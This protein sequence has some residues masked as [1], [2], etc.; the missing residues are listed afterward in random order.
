MGMIS[1]LGASVEATWRGLIAGLSA[2]RAVSSFDTEGFPSRIAAEIR[3]FDPV[4][5]LGAKEARRMARFTQLAFVALEQALQQAALNLQAEDRTRVGLQIGSA[6]GGLPVIEEQ[7]LVLHHEGARRLNPIFV[8]TVIVSAAPCHI[9]VRYGIRG[10]SGAPAAACATGVVAIGDALHWLQRGEVDVVLAGGTESTISPLALASFS[11]LG[12]LSTCN[13]NPQGACRPFDAKR[14]GT[15]LG[16]G[17][18][19]L[20]LETLDHARQRGAPIQGEVLGYGFSEDGYHVAAPDP[21][22][23]GAALAMKAALRT[24]GIAP[25]EVDY[26]VAHGTGTPLNDVAETKAI[27]LVFGAHASRL[28]VSSNKGGLGHTLGAA[29]AVSTVVAVKAIQEGLLPPTVNLET[30]DP[31]CDL[32]YVPRV[33]RR[34]AVHTAVVNAF[35]FGGQ[36]ASLVVRG[37]NGR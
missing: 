27:H 9:A 10:P 7:T 12:A 11:R 13:D 34:A 36:N 31:D 25:E 21:N 30:P 1:P 18:A 28:A 32:D 2:V 22:G 8:P 35:G 37:W 29:G 3:D 20:V 4:E 15:V 24:A 14:D 6:I 5:H 23:E 26:I 33:P 17:A 19:M 16:E